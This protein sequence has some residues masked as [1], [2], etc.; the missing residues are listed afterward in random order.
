MGSCF[1][2]ES[3]STSCGLRGV[4]PL[5]RRTDEKGIVKE[6]KQMVHGEDTGGN[7]DVDGI[8]YPK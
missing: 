1:S 8:G 3:R 5:K 4:P 2:I 6:G 7:V